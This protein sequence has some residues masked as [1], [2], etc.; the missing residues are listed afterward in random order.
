MKKIRAVI[1]ADIIHSTKMSNENKL[2]L[3]EGI[4]GTLK[5][6]DKDYNTRSETYRGDSFQCL[7]NNPK[8][9]LRVALIIRTFIRSLNP[10]ESHEVKS[11]VNPGRKTN[12]LY[13]IWLTDVR[14][15]I[16]I[17]NVDLEMK[18]ISTSDGEAFQLSGRMLDELKNS[19]Q[20]FSIASGDKYKDEFKIESALLDNILN[21]TTALQCEVINLKLLGY[22][23]IEIA[24]KIQIQ[25]AAVNQRSVSGAWN[26]INQMVNYFENIYTNG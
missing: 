11:L 25:Q 9:A 7:V 2:W 17:G 3:Y 8:D 22:T 12:I 20:R 24:K 21:R 23:E 4:K 16:G 6:I 13:P 5:K 18:K 14:M 15:A 19:K 26:V 10:S 1:T